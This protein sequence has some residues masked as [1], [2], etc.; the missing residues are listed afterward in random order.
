LKPTERLNALG[1]ALPEPPAPVGSYVGATRVGQLLFVAGHTARRP[2]HPPTTGIVGVNVSAEDAA[3]DAARAALNLLA[4]AD[5]VVGLDSVVAVVSLRGYVRSRDDFVAHPLVVN[6]ASELLGKIF[7]DRPHS[8]AAIG[9]SSL[10][11]GACVEVEAI[12][13]VRER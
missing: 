6:G 11:G 7:P 4:A 2:H 13:E 1:L 10:P 3:A 8:R 9:V 12:F 5:R